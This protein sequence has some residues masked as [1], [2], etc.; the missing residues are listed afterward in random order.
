MAWK[1]LRS[2][3][4]KRCGVPSALTSPT[5]G[6]SVSL[7]VTLDHCKVRATLSETYCSHIHLD[8][9]N[10]GATLEAGPMWWPHTWP[11]NPYLSRPEPTQSPLTMECIHA[12]YDGASWK[13]A[14]VIET[15]FLASTHPVAPA[16]HEN[17]LYRSH[18]PKPT[19][20]QTQCFCATDC[21]TE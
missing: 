1:P 18:C 12:L 5:R 8:T 6:Y 20:Q 13:H 17:R 3:L 16:A 7:A 9:Y 15:S 21:T 4:Y 19:S 11:S 14:K 2:R 10:I